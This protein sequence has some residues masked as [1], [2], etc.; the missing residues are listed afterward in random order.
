MPTEKVSWQ[1][2]GDV[3]HGMKCGSVDWATT[4]VKEGIGDACPQLEM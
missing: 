4:G 3:F 2:C 1:K